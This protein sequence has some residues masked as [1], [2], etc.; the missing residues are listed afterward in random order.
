MPDED[1][2]TLLNIFVAVKQIKTEQKSQ[3][4]KINTIHTT[5]HGKPE[6]PTTGAMTRLDRAEQKLKL[7]WIA[8][9]G[10]VAAICRA[11]WTDITGK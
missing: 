5:L 2:P 7:L 1:E 10:S 11:F 9:A 3:G 8:V 6:N 4:E